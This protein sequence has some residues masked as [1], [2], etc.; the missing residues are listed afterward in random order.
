MF[1]GVRL[2]MLP[3]TLQQMRAAAAIPLF[4]QVGHE[5]QLHLGI[6]W[7]RVPISGIDTAC[8]STQKVCEGKHA[9]MLMLIKT[10]AGAGSQHGGT[11]ERCAPRS[12]ET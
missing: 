2:A 11:G 4:Q 3:L 9:L 7:F 10:H 8:G 5:F 12:A 6:L 1:A